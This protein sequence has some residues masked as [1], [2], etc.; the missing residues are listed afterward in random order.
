MTDDAFDR[1]FADALRDYAADAPVEVKSRQ[2]ARAIIATQRRRSGF[3][4]A[5]DRGGHPTRIWIVMGALLLLASIASISAVGALLSRPRPTLDPGRPIPSTLFGSFR[6]QIAGQGPGVDFDFYHVDFTSQTLLYG[7]TKEG[8][9]LPSAAFAVA[10]WAGRAVAFVGSADEAG[11]VLIEAAP[12]CG[13]A[14]YNVRV[15]GSGMTMTPI[16]DGCAR[17]VA[18]LTAMP[19]EHFPE[20]IVAGQR[21]DSLAFT[22]PFS[23]TM[24]VMDLGGR[25][26]RAGTDHALRLGT[27]YWHSYFIDDLPIGRDVCDRSK[28]TL[29][30]VLDP[31]ATGDWLRS[32]GL[33]VSG[34]AEIPVDGRIALRWDVESGDTTTTGA[35]CDEAAVLWTAD[36]ELRAAGFAYYAIPTG[37]DTILYVVWSDE[38][39]FESTRAGA[40]KLVRSMTF[41]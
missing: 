26:S 7:P 12:P 20:Q 8:D 15:D 6:V 29:P 19:W 11:E 21:H 27:A 2:F 1:L 35:T 5:V 17:R 24:P 36:G 13:P 39:S 28:G 25:L 40:E 14:R 38:G 37:T 34:P 3:L 31:V 30:D 9:T 33:R 4:A 41:D 10:D 22:E 16:S 32:S 18:I 23:F